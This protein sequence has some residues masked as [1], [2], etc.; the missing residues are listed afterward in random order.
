MDS[1]TTYRVNIEQ[2]VELDADRDGRLSRDELSAFN[3][4]CLTETF[5]ERV[6]QEHPTVNGYLVSVRKRPHDHFG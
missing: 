3:G 5:V 6:F 2:F 1:M 4:H